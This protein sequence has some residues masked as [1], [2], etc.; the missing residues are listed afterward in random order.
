MDV[1]TQTTIMD[2]IPFSGSSFCFAAVA[3]EMESAVETVLAATTAVSWS[4]CFSCA[5]VEMESTAATDADAPSAK[6]IPPPVGGGF[7][8]FFFGGCAVF[9]LEFFFLLLLFF[10]SH[11]FV[12][13]LIERISF[14]YNFL[15]HLLAFLF[16]IHSILW[17]WRKKVK[18]HT[19][20]HIRGCT[21]WQRC[22]TGFIF[23]GFWHIL[24]REKFW[25]VTGWWKNSRKNLTRSHRLIRLQMEI[26]FW[27]WKHCCP[28]CRPKNRQGLL[29]W[30]NGWKSRISGIITI[31]I[32]PLILRQ[33]HFLLIP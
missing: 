23:R 32:L 27:F 11:T 31:H 14:S 21:I 28:I 9:W 5:A 2:A 18:I 10:F 13:Y 24:Q 33:W 17:Y 26:L 3:M 12:I 6:D 29:F 30:L 19:C 1:E 25:Q 7:L 8:M 16:W 15:S 22:Y 20:L 4:Y